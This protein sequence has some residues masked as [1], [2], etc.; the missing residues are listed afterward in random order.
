[1]PE[2]IKTYAVRRGQ[3]LPHACFADSA[4]PPTFAARAPSIRSDESDTGRACGSLEIFIAVESRRSLSSAAALIL[5]RR[6]RRFLIWGKERFDVS[7]Y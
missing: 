2:N 1:M 3:P 7:R 5:Y 6:A 4:M